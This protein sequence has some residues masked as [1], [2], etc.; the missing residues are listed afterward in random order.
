[1]FRSDLVRVIVSRVSLFL[2][3]CLGVYI[4]YLGYRLVDRYGL[5]TPEQY[6]VDNK[7]TLYEYVRNIKTG[8]IQQLPNGRYPG[9]LIPLPAEN[10]LS[11][12]VIAQNGFIYIEDQYPTPDDGVY[13][14]V[15]CPDGSTT[16]SMHK[17]IGRKNAFEVK[18]LDGHWVFVVRSYGDE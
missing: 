11:R 15:Y 13:Y 14:L 18:S 7:A 4:A 1:M 16:F 10:F 17:A 2:V 12:R 9:D 3:V 5:S 8:V 6:F